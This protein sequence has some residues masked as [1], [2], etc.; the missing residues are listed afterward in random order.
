[1]LLVVC[2]LSH[3]VCGIAEADGNVEDKWGSPHYNT[4]CWDHTK[5]NTIHS[6]V[7]G[8]FHS[9]PKM[10]MR[11]HY[12]KTQGITKVK[13]IKHLG[14]KLS[15]KSIQLFWDI[16]S[17]DQSGRLSNIIMP[18]VMPPAWVKSDSCTRNQFGLTGQIRIRFMQIWNKSNNTQRASAPLKQISLCLRLSDPQQT[19][20]AINQAL[21]L[22]R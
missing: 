8:I 16:F 15:I 1:M 22:S 19:I 9:K 14:T 11:W 21:C 3:N 13:M 7:A 12:S 17:F 2:L 4:F 20:K 6:I 10:S 5:L 18:G